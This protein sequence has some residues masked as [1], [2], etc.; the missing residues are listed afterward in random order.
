MNNIFFIGI[1]F[2]SSINFGFF[3]DKLLVRKV[4]CNNLDYLLN[5]VSLGILIN[6]FL[7]WTLGI[8]KL[9]II[10]FS[11]TYLILNI[12]IF[13]FNKKKIKLPIFDN[14]KIIHQIKNYK[15]FYILVAI[16]LFI[17]LLNGYAPPTDIDSLNY[18]LSLPKKDIEFGKIIIHG[19]NE[20]EYMPMLIEN[21]MRLL[22]L[23]G[24]ETIGHQF[25]FF[26]F[27]LI[28]ISI[29]RIGFNLSLNNKIT[30]LSIVFF[31][32][33]KGNM[34]L[35][36]TT[37]NELILSFF[38]LIC[39]NNYILFKKNL[40]DFF[41]LHLVFAATA[42]LY[43]KYHGIIFCLGFFILI[44]KD[45]YLQK[46]K[47]QKKYILYLVLP[48]IFFSPLLIRNFILVGDPLFPLFYFYNAIS[49]TK[50][51]GI[52]TSFISFFLTPINF[53]LFGNR[54]FD[55]QYLGSPYIIFLLYCSILFIK[56]IKIF[57]D[58]L[59]ICLIYYTVWFYGLSQQVRY[60]IPIL[61]LLCILCS[62][63]FFELLNIFIN[64]HLRII[65]FSIFTIFFL[66]Q[67]IFLSGYTLLKLPVAV[68][69]QSKQDYL[70]DKHSDYSF[71]DSCTFLNKNLND[72]NYINI[73]IFLSY[74]CPQ[75]KS[76]RNINDKFFNNKN[77]NKDEILLHLKKNKIKY[78]FLQT[79]DRKI[80][81]TGFGFR[82]LSIQN[83]NFKVLIDLF[84]NNI[85]FQDNQAIIYEINF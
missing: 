13:F 11:Y 50:E 77:L 43:T 9:N 5:I 54:Y 51:Y 60:L 85:V 67:I 57:N 10:F 66:N 31:I 81:N 55:G 73:S 76:L 47:F 6:F 56:K 74:Y 26:I 75:K 2:L 38:L 20:S 52:D 36:N 29:Y 27:V 17:Y 53:V 18:H 64:K 32:L 79:K 16:I 72:N 78:I 70:K 80:T 21:I 3:F 25:N 30:L 82:E 40:D 45:T 62:F 7:I 37:H 41:A 44:I 68:G 22:L 59:I 69:I 19:W 39:V 83:P 71:Y 24:S 12:S 1:F 63:I 61:S 42:L 84:K 49:G 14:I 65:Y 58:I 23:F 8:Y 35:I 48:I 15:Y 34:W 28:I 33:I 46:I 4:N